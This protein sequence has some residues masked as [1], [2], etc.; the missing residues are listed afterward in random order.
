MVEVLAHRGPDGAGDWADA[1]AG[2]AL[3]HRRLAILGLGPAGTQP[4][5]SADGRYVITYNGEI[6]NFATLR[7]D[8]AASGI[9]FVGMSD[10][11]VLLASIARHG[12]E[13]ALDAANGM[14]AFALWDRAN[15][16]LTLARDRYGQKPLYYGWAG[17][18]FVF[19]SETKALAR[20]PDFVREIDRDALA[21][22]FRF[23][24]IP[25]PR[26]IWRGVCKLLPGSTVTLTR[27]DLAGRRM[28]EPVPYWSAL[29]VAR[30]GL[31]APFTGSPHEAVD[32]L[33]SVLGDAVG[34]CMVSDVPLGAF[35]SG[36]IDS[37]TVVA[38][39]QA[40]STRPVRTFTIGFR[41]T[42]Y[43][44]AR[45]AKAV[46]QHLGTDHTE[47]YVTAAE[48]QQVIVDL[49]EIYDEPFADSSQIP[50]FLVSRLAREH[51]IVSLSGDGGDEQFA[52][53]NRY[54]W[55]AT[56]DRAVTAIPAPL[57]RVAASMM[58]SLGPA[59]WDTLYSGVAWYKESESRQVQVGHKV[60]KLAGLLG[61]R[62]RHAL[63]LDLLSQWNCPGQLVPGAREPQTRAHDASSW[64]GLDG[65]VHDMMALD[66]SG[67]L[68]D[69]IL[70]KLDR[71]TMAVGLEGRV[72]LLDH[73]VGAFAWSLPLAVKLRDGRGKWPMRALLARYLP[74]ALIE[75]PKM[76]FGV[77][78]GRWLRSDLRD[79]AE[80]L[81]DERTLASDGILDPAPIRQAWTEHL[82]GHRN[83]EHRLWTVLM[84]Q[85]WRGAA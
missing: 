69:D 32:A 1:D 54:R 43:D 35:L 6:Y 73:H 28:P 14:F 33:E 76:G 24:A 67:Y 71:A 65:F 79:W 82:S 2:I 21:G 78:I 83:W 8:L 55:A 26:S 40:R 84:F 4:M 75:R 59:A 80:A 72:P 11:E 61:V 15:R 38:L 53:Y 52:G 17:N 81:L 31:A 23:A 49:P 27:A 66:T 7:A 10:T 46:A 77:P 42:G 70:V 63:Y 37:T 48:A 25:A 34:S 12:V 5:V 16:T 51:V 3:G 36:G 13:S 39:M 22:Y 18:A 56:L 74:S 41:E 30:A 29:E 47:H 62:D 45:Y 58:L 19:G 50:T 85:A 9:N 44:E 64:P 57:R 60:H 20:H 68:P